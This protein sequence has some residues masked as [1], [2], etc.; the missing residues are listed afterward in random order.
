M[1]AFLLLVLI[2]AAVSAVHAT[3]PIM[4]CGQRIP[5]G[6]TGELMHDL[7]CAG[8]RGVELVDDATLRLNGF[9]L[10]GA[11]PGTG[12]LCFCPMTCI[13][14]GPGTISGFDGG[15]VTYPCIPNVGS[16]FDPPTGGRR[17]RRYMQVRD[18][19]LRGNEVGLSTGSARVDLTNVVVDQSET[20][21]ID[22]A[23]LR[24][25]NVRVTDNEMGG[26]RAW[27]VDFVGLVAQGNGAAGQWYGTGCGLYLHGLPPR[28]SHLTDSVFMGNNGLGQGYD[29]VISAPGRR[30]LKLRNATCGKA[31][32]IGDNYG[33]VR[34]FTCD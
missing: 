27:R 12:V 18:V 8:A 21:G 17:E 24:G 32:R 5:A 34:S 4:E 10:R 16:S 20:W 2:M 25:T 28:P 15:I 31:A 14:V 9:S 1:R 26:V 3:I 7:D 33:I 30:R 11:P 19:T 6:E 23:R 29:V 22:G 13:I